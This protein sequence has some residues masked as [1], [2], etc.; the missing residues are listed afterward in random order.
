MIIQP[1]V[2]KVG[3]SAAGEQFYVL[4]PAFY[5][6]FI[7]I[8]IDATSAGTYVDDQKT[9]IDSIIYTVNDTPVSFPFA[10][11]DGDVLGITIVKTS[12][13]EMAV[14]ELTNASISPYTFSADGFT[15]VYPPAHNATYV[16]ATTQYG[17]NFEPYNAT[18]PASSLTGVWTNNAWISASGQTTNQRFHIDLGSEY[19]ISRIKYENGHSSGIYIDTGAQDITIWASNSASD[20]DDL[21]YANDGTWTQMLGQSSSK[22]YPHIA[23]DQSDTKYLTFNNSTA[24]RYWAIKIANSQGCLS[25]PAICIRRIELQQ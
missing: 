4:F 6:S 5:K 22:F 10:V 21:V 15:S 12:K 18:N 16:K 11:A 9:N 23:N 8:N 14:L 24:Y 19:A 17:T 2:V 13:E 3:G 7:D 25:I 20:F 1:H